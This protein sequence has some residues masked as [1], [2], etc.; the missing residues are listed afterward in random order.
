MLQFTITTPAA[1]PGLLADIC[2]ALADAGVD[3]QDITVVEDRRKGVIILLA[4]PSDT[5]QRVLE[6][7]GFDF[8]VHRPLILALPDKP[9]AIAPVTEKLRDHAINIR[10][11]HVLHQRDGDAMI[12]VDTDNNDR[13]RELLKRKLASGGG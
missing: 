3:I 10:S 1:S 7:E 11:M 2:R 4:Q 12:A 13:A 5:A 8:A 9:G 6:D